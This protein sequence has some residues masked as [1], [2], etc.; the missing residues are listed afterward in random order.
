LLDGCLSGVYIRECYLWVEFV[1]CDFRQR[2]R[3]VL[4]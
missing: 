4:A 2:I 3:S 1:L